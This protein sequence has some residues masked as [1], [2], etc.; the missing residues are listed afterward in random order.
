[1]DKVDTY[2]RRILA[3]I[4]EEDCKTTSHAIVR[5]LNFSGNN[6][7]ARLIRRAIRRLINKG[8]LVYSYQFGSSYIEPSFERPVRVSRKIVIKPPTIAY[9]NRSGE[10]VIDILKGD[11]FGYGNHPTTRLSLKIMEGV[12]ESLL[13]AGYPLKTAWDVGTGSGI[14]S[15]AAVKLGVQ[16]VLASDTDPCARFEAQRN[17]E[18]NGLVDRIEVAANRLPRLQHEFSLIMANLRSPTVV[19]LGETFY[20][21]LMR[22]CYLVVSG[23]RADEVET[24]AV[25]L[26]VFGFTAKR[27]AFEKGWAGIAFLK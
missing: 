8:A 6:F 19:A 4:E 24:L 9:V 27:V 25:D 3:L 1:L 10:V 15:I 13:S 5:R 18:L 14:L 21:A 23:M 20:N 22:N 16:W 7:D 12:I 11:A 26:A 17:V 2:C